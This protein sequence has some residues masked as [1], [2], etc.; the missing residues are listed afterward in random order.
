M[1]GSAGNFSKTLNFPHVK[2]YFYHFVDR[3]PKLTY[4]GEFKVGR[5]AQRKFPRP[6]TIRY[7]L[8]ISLTINYAP[9]HM[10]LIHIFIGPIYVNDPSLTS[11]IRVSSLVA[12]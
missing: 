7:T 10:D 2:S 1:I 4:V 6:S 11:Y 8:F 12:T 9:K 3:A 5:K